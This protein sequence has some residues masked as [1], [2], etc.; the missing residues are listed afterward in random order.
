MAWSQRKAARIIRASGWNTAYVTDVGL[1]GKPDEDIFAFAWRDDRIILTHDEDFLDDRRFPPH[2]NPGVIILPGAIGQTPG[3][4]DAV[5]GV[6]RLVGPYR[7]AHRRAKIQITEEGIWT[8]KGFPKGA[9]SLK[10]RR[11]KFGR[12]GEVWEW[13]DRKQ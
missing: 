13:I 8:I 7:G 1:G 3:L 11:V 9:V 4:L 10:K 2:R 12:H 6:L 5:S